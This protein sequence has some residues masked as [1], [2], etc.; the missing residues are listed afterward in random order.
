MDYMGMVRCV[1][2]F[3]LSGSLRERVL[4]DDDLF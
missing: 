2:S 3:N 4:C 1:E